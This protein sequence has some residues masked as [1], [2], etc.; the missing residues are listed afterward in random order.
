MKLIDLHLRT[1]DYFGKKPL[2]HD[3][4]T[5]YMKYLIRTYL[6]NVFSLWLTSKIFG[7][8]AYGLQT[9]GSLQ[10]ITTSGAGTW[11]PPQRVGTNA[12]IVV[13]TLQKD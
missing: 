1:I 10:V 6:F 8:F 12:E 9:T 4:T 11:G 3:I 7:K 2:K 13:I 5:L